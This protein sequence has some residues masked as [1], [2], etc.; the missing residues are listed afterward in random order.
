MTF[1]VTM[2]KDVVVEVFVRMTWLS[3]TGQSLVVMYMCIYDAIEPDGFIKNS[4][5]EFNECST[6]IKN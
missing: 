6:M 4:P 5:R 3:V 1:Q 2:V